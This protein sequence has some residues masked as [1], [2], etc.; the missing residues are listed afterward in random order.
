MAQRLRNITGRRFGS[1]LVLGLNRATNPRHYRWLCLCDCGR[2]KTVLAC[3]LVRGDVKTC[4]NAQCPFSRKLRFPVSPD[5]DG[6]RMQ[7][8]RM[9]TLGAKRK[10]RSFE[11]DQQFFFTLLEQRCYYCGATPANKS[12][13]G[14]TTEPYLLQRNR[15]NRVHFGICR[16]QRSNVLLGL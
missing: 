5:G 7:V 13:R 16:R 12:V 14:G 11:L 8:W 9:Y 4:N 2:A 6:P 1:L 10:G 3:H 15:Q